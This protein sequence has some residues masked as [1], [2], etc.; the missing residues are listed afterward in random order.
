MA[1]ALNM[2][3]RIR[4]WFEHEPIMNFCWLYDSFYTK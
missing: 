2:L 1:K 3:I 4:A